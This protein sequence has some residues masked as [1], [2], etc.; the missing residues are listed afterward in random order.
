MEASIEINLL[1]TCVPKRSYC[2]EPMAKPHWTQSKNKPRMPWESLGK[3]LGE[4]RLV[5]EDFPEEVVLMLDRSGEWAG[6][7]KA[8]GLVVW[9][10][11][12]GIAGG[13]H[14]F[15]GLEEQQPERERVKQKRRKGEREGKEKESSA[16]VTH[17]LRPHL[18]KN[19]FFPSKLWYH[20]NSN[21]RK[22]WEK[23]KIVEANEKNRE[24]NL[25]KRD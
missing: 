10:G 22:E 2:T 16:V 1:W 15:K 7:N 14:M 24:V 9:S 20:P 12:G 23:K 4:G 11:E 5:R 21:Q 3:F 8:K 25:R 17:H 19:S 6:D 13:G 18:P